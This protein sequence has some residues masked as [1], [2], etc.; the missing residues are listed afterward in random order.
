MQHIGSLHR[1]HGGHRYP[2][3]QGWAGVPLSHRLL[4]ASF[5]D[6]KQA[7]KAG[8]AGVQ[9]RSIPESALLSTVQGHGSKNY[10]QKRQPDHPGVGVYAAILPF[11]SL[12]KSWGPPAFVL[13]NGTRKSPITGRGSPY[14]QAL[15]LWDELEANRAGWT[16]MSRA[17][18]PLVSG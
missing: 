18:K 7:Q 1:W 10:S 9:Q 16:K 2:A 12:R 5:Q 17:S 15:A 11:L 14:T 8:M 4:G 6:G 3:G 13:Q